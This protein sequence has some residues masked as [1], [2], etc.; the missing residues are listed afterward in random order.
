MRSTCSHFMETI[1][2]L[3][4]PVSTANRSRFP[5][6]FDPA[7]VAILSSSSEESR[8]SLPE[9]S[10]GIR[11]CRTGFPMGNA[12]PHS[13]FLDGNIEQTGEKEKIMLDGLRTD[14]FSSFITI[15]GKK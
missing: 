2:P 9:G 13:L 8:R 7:A 5:N 4:M 1:S 15:F 14:L 11:I 3:L 12:I 6:S 10:L